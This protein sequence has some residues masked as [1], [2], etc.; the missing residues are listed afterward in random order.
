LETLSKN[1]QY[2][3]LNKINERYADKPTMNMI[4]MEAQV[5]MRISPKK[6]GCDIIFI[7]NNYGL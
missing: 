5:K 3:E 7:F 4:S 6:A 2:I 1:T